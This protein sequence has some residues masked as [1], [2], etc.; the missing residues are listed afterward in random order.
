[1]RLARERGVATTNDFMDIAN[2][3]E[4]VD[5]VIDATGVAAVRDQL[6]QHFQDSGNRHT[7][8]MHETI[9]L[10]MMSLSQGKLVASKHGAHHYG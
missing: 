7:V 10:L 3:G 1:M 8:I 5:I 4:E 6:R 9:V 2:Q